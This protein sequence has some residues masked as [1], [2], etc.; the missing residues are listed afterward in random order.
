[1]QQ[2][3]CRNV[4]EEI[5]PFWDKLTTSEQESLCRN[6]LEKSFQ[7]GE[8]IHSAHGKC[9]GAIVVKSGCIRCLYTVR[10]RKRSYPLPPLQR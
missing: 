4:Y 3:S 1:M 7:K 8:T 10:K 6:T 2:L 5:F 9:T